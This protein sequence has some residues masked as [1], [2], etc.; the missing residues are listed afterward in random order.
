MG[1]FF[2]LNTLLGMNDPK[3]Y[4]DYQVFDFVQDEFF[5]Q[6]AKT[7]DPTLSDFWDK[8]LA[9]HPEKVPVVEEAVAFVNAFKYPTAAAL[10][11]KEYVNLYETVLKHKKVVAPTH[12]IKPW[13]WYQ[14]AAAATLL[15]VAYF[16][17]QAYQKPI[18]PQTEHRIVKHTNW[19]ER[20]TFQ[21]TDGTMVYMN[22]GSQVAIPTNFGHEKR[23]IH[24]IGEAFFEVAHDPS[25][26]FTV[27]TQAMSVTALGTAFGVNAYAD[28]S[29]TH[30]TLVQGKVQVVALARGASKILAPG[31]Q[32]QVGEAGNLQV[33]EVDTE[34]LLAWKDGVITFNEAS[35][36]QMVQKIERWYGV[37]IMVEG[38]P[39]TA[40]FQG[41]FKN[42]GLKTLLNALAFSSGFEFEIDKKNVTLKFSQN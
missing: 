38:I 28:D 42:P 36:D 23:D 5:V 13:V 37:K 17:F 3:K 40:P 9:N 21:L 16:V 14:V 22:A 6:W 19:G 35:F 15:L 30:A 27:H 18:V 4:V 29:V 34:Y 31:E 26:P 11:D 24:I 41:K 10:D 32:A 25:R 2:K 12:K 7:K 20:R 39:R 8:W 33:N 1:S